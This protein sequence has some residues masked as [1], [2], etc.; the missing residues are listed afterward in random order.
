[1][2]FYLR[3]IY[4]SNLFHSLC[5][6]AVGAIL[7]VL[8]GHHPND[9][10]YIT[11]RHSRNFAETGL[12]SW[13]TIPPY[14]MG[15]TSPFL[16]FV[17]GALGF[18]FGS[19]S[20]PELSLYLNAFLLLPFS[21]LIY[22]IVKLLVSDR[23]VA[24]CSTALVCWNSYN[25]RIY[26]QGFEALLFSLVFL[27]S[28]YFL[29]IRKYEFGFLL[30]G[31]APLVRPE[32]IFLVPVLFYFLVRRKK[33]P[34]Q[35]LYYLVIPALYSIY[36]IFVY[37]QIV[38]Q[39]VL[40]KKAFFE[41][42]LNSVGE[43]S[44]IKPD[45]KIA[46]IHLAG[47]W[48]ILLK[49][50]LLINGEAGVRLLGYPNRLGNFF[51]SKGNQLLYSILFLYLIAIYYFLKKEG[52]R[53]FEKLSFLS[54][55]FFFVFF[56]LYSVRV[57]FWYV[58]L[59][60]SSILL[61]FCIGPIVFVR[62]GS[63]WWERIRNAKTLRTVYRVIFL[64]VFLLFADKNLYVLNKGTHPYDELRG[65]IYVPAY[66]DKDEFERYLGYRK[67]AFLLEGD[68]QG[69]V[70]TN[71]V[72]VFG[73]YSKNPVID[74]FGLCSREVIDAYREEKKKGRTPDLWESYSVISYLRP[75][76]VMGGMVTPEKMSKLSNPRY[77]LVQE[78]GYTAFGKPIRI[79]RKSSR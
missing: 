46:W 9:D 57:E 3:K 41:L 24:L 20:I 17:L 37:G 12:L 21:A 39:S 6:G 22:A 49:P 67:A 56:L 59:A 2:P 43:P 31:I 75:E 13:N 61:L 54:Y 52:W 11:F 19:D 36:A 42:G 14:E 64:F 33:L 63:V 27:G 78:V 47:I 4:R 8:M 51:L 25:I 32:G 45:L 77:E 15:S 60:N 30:A 29:Y 70:F 18:V 28:I 40:A 71:E 26:S 35:I 5:I 68:V 66:R 23:L 38:P 72:G 58:P 74:S 65:P 1:M 44:E 48:D 79:F 7:L 16:A 55:P 53:G 69:R 50:I 10:A 76:Y 34:L 62:L 73:Y